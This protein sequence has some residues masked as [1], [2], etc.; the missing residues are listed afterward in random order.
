MNLT[1]LLAVVELERD[2]PGYKDLPR[3]LVTW[4]QDAGGFALAGLTLWIIYSFLRTPAS[5][6]S[7]RPLVS[8]LMF[9]NFA[10]SVALAVF[11]RIRYGIIISAI[12][13][14]PP[15]TSQQ[16]QDGITVP[17]VRELT[18]SE[19]S[20]EWMLALSGLLAILGIGEPFVR[21]FFRMR[22]GRIYAI[23]RLSFIESIRRKVV[24]V[25]LIQ[26]AVFLFPA[27]WW[28]VN[29]PEDEIRTAIA[30]L[31]YAMT[32]EFIFVGLLLSGFSIPQDVRSQTIHTIVT[33]PVERFE[34]V[35]GRFIGF[36]SLLTIALVCFS[37]IGLTLISASNVDPV[38]REKSMKARVPIYGKLA[39]ASERRGGGFQGISVGRER[40]YRRYIAGGQGATN[41]AI[42]QFADIS[43]SV[44]DK[45]DAVPVEFA[46]DIYRTTKGEE[47]KGVFL[48]F[49][50]TTWNYTP[51]RDKEY[52][53]RISREL[54]SYPT[55]VQPTDATGWAIID[56]IAEEFGRF[57]IR[58][59]QHYDFHTDTISFPPGLLR[60]LDKAKP[61]DAA[62]LK[63]A[64][65]LRATVRCE[66]ESQ[67]VGV[68]P[69][70]LYLLESE[71]SFALNFF[72]GA[73]GL[74]ARLA[75][76]L[77]IS[78]AFSTYLAGVISF[79]AA[80]FLFLLGLIQ[81]FIE[82]LARGQNIGGG[83]FESVT[84]LVR[85]DNPTLT[86][87]NPTPTQQAI[88]ATDQGFRWL[89]RRFLDV[90]PDIDRYSWTNYVSEGFSI[91]PEFVVVNLIVLAGYLL[92]WFVVSYYLM[93]S[94]EIA[95]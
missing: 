95:S 86:Y 52:Q 80:A 27:R 88:A 82:S 12:G 90:I 2:P 89:L 85:G 1:S 35:L 54:G 36:L 93:K 72:K 38:A 14:V 13:Y 67:F 30:V 57:E 3:L 87:D 18:S 62:V 8:R 53:D 33:K 83:P 73:I 31:N 79:L 78:I 24:W 21:D 43:S 20:V 29:N 68:A 94:R 17:I 65:N 81:E 76:V 70:D 10:M 34:I 58:N 55:N 6:G 42:W 71:G 7:S 51:T 32:A 63:E 75:I 77:A 19:K 11:A 41:R 50:F 26:L 39:F 28:F 61:T 60:N 23:A 47:G 25:F 56:A 4:L 74:W 5:A 91:S 66:T 49:N 9:G 45:R 64:F 16:T 15:I 37:G 84:R 22:W 44:I 59:V 92:P 46:F 40:E 48:T 69:Y